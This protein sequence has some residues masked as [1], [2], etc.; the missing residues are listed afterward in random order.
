[1]LHR[2]M[3]LNY[4]IKKLRVLFRKLFD[5]HR[6]D[7]TKEEIIIKSVVKSLLKNPSVKIINDFNSKK[8]LLQCCDYVVVVSNMEVKF[9]NHK[10]FFDMIVSQKLSNEL[11]NII[12]DKLE[13]ERSSVEE[14]I[15]S[16]RSKIMY[17]TI[18]DLKIEKI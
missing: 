9:T 16:F 5:S 13:E 8:I 18:D 10:V 1:M 15:F 7:Y 3:G 17:E 4:K 12:F 11:F 14:D 6:K 2:E